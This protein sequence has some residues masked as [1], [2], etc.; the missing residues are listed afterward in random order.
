MIDA[1]TLQI[2]SHVLCNGKRERVRGLDEDNGL[3]IRFPAE[4]V[5]A[6]EVEPILITGIL[7]KE[8]GF[9]KREWSDEHT[10][11]ATVAMLCSADLLVLL[12]DVDGL[13]DGDPSDP[14]SHFIPEVNEIT[15]EIIG[16]SQGSGSAVGTGGMLS[17]IEAA[18]IAT[19]AGI[20]TVI[21]GNKDPALLYKL[22]ESDD[23]RCTYFKA[24]K[25]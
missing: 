12:T 1:K 17:K 9:D 10:L 11:S 19:E 24:S 14:N 22:F 16:Y 3:I 8:L 4:Y 15:T 13:Y 21:I 18:K 7:L 6:S 20:D 25:H 2:G 23:A 5:H